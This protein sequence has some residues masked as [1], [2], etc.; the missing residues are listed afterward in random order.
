VEGL[1]AGTGGVVK[2]DVA[3]RPREAAVLLAEADEHLAVGA[4][5]LRVGGA[6]ARERLA[7]S[8]ATKGAGGM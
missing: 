4:E 8:R 5:E 6:K 2:G 1:V 7:E 3:E